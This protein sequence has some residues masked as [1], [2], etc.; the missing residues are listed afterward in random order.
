MSY[1]SPGSKQRKIIKNLRDQVYYW[2]GKKEPK[3]DKDLKKKI[4]NLQSQVNY[5]KRSLRIKIDNKVKEA[6]VLIKRL[7]E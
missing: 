7:G 4:K 3:T 2:K 1:N 5:Y 6:D